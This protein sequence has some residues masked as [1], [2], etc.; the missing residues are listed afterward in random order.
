MTAVRESGYYGLVSAN[1]GGLLKIFSS[2]AGKGE[3]YPAVMDRGY[4][5]RGTTGTVF[6]S[7]LLSRA[8]E[9]KM[10]ENGALEIT[11][12]FRFGSYLFPGPLVRILLDAVSSVPGGYRLV[13][14]GIDLIRR[15][16][17]ASFQLTAVPGRVSPW[18]LKRT[19]TFSPDLVVVRDEITAKEERGDW[20]IEI[21]L[22]ER[23][24]S[25]VIGR[26][27]SGLEDEL[28]RALAARGK[29]VV[30]KEFR[31]TASGMK[32]A[33]RCLTPVAPAGGE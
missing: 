23:D 7:F 33:G 9:A 19:I 28:R 8:N 17:K 2:P 25:R 16:K 22:E 14:S 1:C 4:S 6:H 13:K 24:G 30:E 18:R 21:D 11:A 15:R 10:D 3:G 12:S 32:V 31:S 29:A 5:V 27:L 20:E 26:P